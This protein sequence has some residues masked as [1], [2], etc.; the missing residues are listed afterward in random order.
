MKKEILIGFIVA[1]FATICGFYLY[2]Q[3]FSKFGFYETLEIIRE[4]NLFGKVLALASIPNLFVFFIFLKKKQDYRARGVMMTS[5]LILIVM[6]GLKF[7]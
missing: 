5:L 2:V 4:G 7:L 3:L 6:L 1:V